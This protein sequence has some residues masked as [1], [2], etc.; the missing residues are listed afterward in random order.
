MRVA[1]REAEH[2]T[3][4]VRDGAVIM[5]SEVVE[6]EDY[7]DGKNDNGDGKVGD[8]ISA[9]KVRQWRR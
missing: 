1:E 9:P 8:A 7:D 2:V 5:T 3:W 6:R 4:E